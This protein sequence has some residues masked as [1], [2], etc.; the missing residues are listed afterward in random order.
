M[1]VATR[2]LSWSSPAGPARAASQRDPEQEQRAQHQAEAEVGPP[3]PA[4]VETV[5]A[6]LA[7]IEYATRQV[8]RGGD[9]KREHQ[10]P[11]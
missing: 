9:Q 11:N 2:C 3:L 1:L 5:V 8:Q 6:H 10:R 4:E 7:M